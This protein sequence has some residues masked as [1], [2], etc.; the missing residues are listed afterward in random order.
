MRETLRLA[1]SAPFRS[2][3]PLEDTTLSNGKFVV[4][5]DVAITCGIYMMHR[6]PKI[7]GEDVSLYLLT[8]WLFARPLMAITRRPCSSVRS[9]CWMGNLRHFL[10]VL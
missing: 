1:P 3:T 8:I 4:E 5:E 6:D 9:G 10:W 2:V 7:W